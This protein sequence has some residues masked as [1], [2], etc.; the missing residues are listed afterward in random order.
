ML[1]DKLA[2]QLLPT[3]DNSW[4]RRYVSY[5]SA[6]TDAPI[7][8]HLG[9][10]LSILATVAGHRL[11][12]RFAG[13][14]LPTNL[15]VLVVGSSGEAR[16]T[17]AIRIGSDILAEVAPQLHGS[18][19]G[20]EEGLVDQLAEQENQLIVYGEFGQFLEKSQFGYLSALKTRYTQVYDG[21][22]TSRSLARGKRH[23]AEHPRLSL[24]GGVTLDFLEAFTTTVDWGGGFLNRFFVIVAER[25]RTLISPPEDVGEA[26]A[27][28]AQLKTLY[29]GTLK[30]YAGLDPAAAA[31]WES[32]A[33]RREE[34][35]TNETA[36]MPELT[37]GLTSRTPTVLLKIALLLAFDEGRCHRGRDAEEEYT[38]SLA[39]MKC[40]ARI[41]EIQ[42]DSAV[43]LA[44]HIA[45][46]ADRRDRRTVLRA[47]NGEAASL[48]ELIQRSRIQKRKVIP[49]IE[50]LVEE[51][52]L[53]K[54]ATETSVSYRKVV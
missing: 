20:S 2:L 19:P 25:Q 7:G 43:M 16:K 34:R 45:E 24:L 17:T 14:R 51:G 41:A 38:V 35:L 3:A 23:V 21:D 30:T 48:G 4:L 49:V 29:E 40:A 11:M 12:G 33:T 39:N 10:G 9:T 37:R 26:V 36:F 18:Q 53:L 42:E 5:A 8:F 31:H 32:W 50:S 6:R 52:A 22:R 54:I 28:G 47:L 27:L 15:W 44:Q 1:T 13:S 46:N